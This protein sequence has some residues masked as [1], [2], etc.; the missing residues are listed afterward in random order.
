MPTTT[1]ALRRT[2][3]AASLI[4]N[5]LTVLAVAYLLAR[6]Y[7]PWALALLGWN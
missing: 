3:H 6:C 1:D 7:V 4:K 2:A 5:A